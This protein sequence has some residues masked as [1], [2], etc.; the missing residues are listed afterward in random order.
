MAAGVDAR[1]TAV[2]LEM[3]DSYAIGLGVEHAA[4]SMVW[5]VTDMNSPLAQ[6]AASWPEPSARLDE[7]F[8]RGL[9]LILDH[10]ESIIA[11]GENRSEVTTHH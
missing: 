4:P 10:V 2:V 3:L 5:E 11:H 9:R 6:A 1:E 8:E 7:A